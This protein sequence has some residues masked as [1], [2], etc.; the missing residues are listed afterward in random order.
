MASTTKY[1]PW[2]K[3]GNARE[4]KT[5]KIM[6]RKNASQALSE[7]KQIKQSTRGHKITTYGCK[8]STIKPLGYTKCRG[9]Q[10][11]LPRLLGNQIFSAGTVKIRF[12][13]KH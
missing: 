10:T 1:R 11:W 7:R 12:K 5:D 4:Q 6:T 8:Q 2:Q 13:L 9:V 3:N